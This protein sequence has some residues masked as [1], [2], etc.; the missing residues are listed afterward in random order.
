MSYRLVMVGIIY[1]GPASAV[2]LF[3]ERYHQFQFM[4]A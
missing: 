3:H 4:K 2:G 1:L